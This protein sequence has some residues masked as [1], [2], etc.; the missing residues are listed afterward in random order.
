MRTLVFKVKLL[1]PKVKTPRHNSMIGIIPRSR[2]L[3]VGTER[4]QQS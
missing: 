2:I 1:N 3:E 4:S